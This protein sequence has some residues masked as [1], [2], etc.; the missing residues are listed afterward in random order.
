MHKMSSTS[1]QLTSPSNLQ[2]PRLQWWY[3]AIVHDRHDA[4]RHH[5]HTSNTEFRRRLLNASF[6]KLTVNCFGLNDKPDSFSFETFQVFRPFN[7]ALAYGA[8][9]ETI[10]LLLSNGV[11]LALT[12]HHGNT[13][14]HVM[15]T[16]AFLK[17]EREELMRDVFNMVSSFLSRTELNIIL[18]QEDQSGFRPLEVAAHYG[19]FV[20]F[21]DMFHTPGGCFSKESTT[22]IYHKQYFDITEYE[23]TLGSR[24]DRSPLTLLGLLDMDA[25]DRKYSAEAFTRQHLH[26]WIKF[27]YRKNLPFFIFWY[28]SRMLLVLAFTT[29]DNTFLPIEERIVNSNLTAEDVT[30]FDR[31]TSMFISNRTVLMT[32]GFYLVVHSFLG[33]LFDLWAMA[34]AHSHQYHENSESR[35]LFKTIRRSKRLVVDYWSYRVSQ[36]TIN[37][38][39]LLSV[40]VRLLRYQFN[41]GLSVLMSNFLY[42]AVLSNI[43]ASFVF[44]LQLVPKIGFYAV[45]IQ[46]M[47]S[48]FMNYF[49]ILYLTVAVP[50]M[51]SFERVINFGKVECEENFQSMWQALYSTFLV[52]FNMLDFQGVRASGEQAAVLYFIHVAF[53][54]L[55]GVLL[56]N[57]LIALF[58]YHVGFVLQ[59]SD[60]IIPVQ[61][62]FLMWLAEER[63]HKILRK[64]LIQMERKCFITDS[65]GNLYVSQILVAEQGKKKV[66]VARSTSHLRE[67]PLMRKLSDISDTLDMA[68]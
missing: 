39:I 57:F 59:S 64:F 44:F 38:G 43:A 37:L 13:C 6:D 27:K 24:R 9:K 42:L 54:L 10:S 3:D 31:T 11:D 49:L 66:R 58:T 30:C 2:L 28:I 35:N 36:V 68:L 50:F 33:L 53:V 55:V 34:V 40:T 45:V 1:I 51:L 20:L 25:I 67:H 47:S 63:I 21:L 8:S 52:T 17:P 23:S 18:L 32:L 60:I 16:M 48:M 19:T 7:L 26:Q 15:V 5:L 61:C 46:R 56:V 41:F 4:V 22:G 65:E 62:I 14:F 12:D 29:F